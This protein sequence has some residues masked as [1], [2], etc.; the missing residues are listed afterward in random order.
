VIEDFKRRNLQPTALEPK[1]SV[2]RYKLL[3]AHEVEEVDAANPMIPPP[4]PK[5]G[6]APPVPTED[7]RIEGIGRVYFLS[8]VGFS[9]DRRRA[10][11]YIA[12]QFHGR[13]YFVEKKHGTWIIDNDY[14]G[15]VCE[16]WV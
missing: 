16:W 1:F 5:P 12:T 10:L 6:V 14:H 13:F 9:A 8:G 4:P 2:D 3:T 15:D 11:V 7:P